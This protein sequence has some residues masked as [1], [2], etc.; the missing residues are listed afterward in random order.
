[1]KKYSLVFLNTIL[2]Y[3]NF[4]LNAQTLQ[5]IPVDMT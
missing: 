5:A 3:G 2:L 1:M 4:G